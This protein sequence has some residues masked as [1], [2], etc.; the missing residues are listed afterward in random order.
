MA[1]DANILIFERIKEELSTGK[2]IRS[3]VDAGFNRALTSIM[4]SNIT[5]IIAAVVLY[6][7]GTGAVKGFALTLM[8]G[9]VLSML[10]AVIVTRCLLKLAVN[11]G[12]LNSLKQLLVQ[13]RRAE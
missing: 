8:I 6:N 1:V 11:A 10:T 3:S 9:I 4:D 5:T 7:L 2:S 13:K 12:L